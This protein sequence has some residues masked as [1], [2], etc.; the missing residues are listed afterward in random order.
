MSAVELNEIDKEGPIFHFE[1]YD[2]KYLKPQRWYERPQFQLVSAIFLVASLSLLIFGVVIGETINQRTFEKMRRPSL[3]WP[4]AIRTPHAVSSDNLQCSMIGATVLLDGGNA[5]DAAVAT[6]ICTSVMLPHS[7]GI[8]GGA[9]MTIVLADGTRV[10]VDG[11]EQAPNASRSNMLN[12]RSPSKGLFVGVP[13][14][15]SALETAWQ[16]YKSGKITWAKL[17]EP[18]LKLAEEG[19]TIREGLSEVINSSDRICIQKGL[20]S[21]AYSEQIQDSNMG[22]IFLS[23]GAPLTRGAV[24]RNPRLG[25]T[26]RNVAENGTW[27]F[28]NG[29]IAQKMIRDITDDGRGIMTLSDLAG[30]AARVTEPLSSTFGAYRV[31]CPGLPHTGCPILLQSLNTLDQ[32][33][34]LS[35]VTSSSYTSS[36]SAHLMAESFK[37]AFAQ[38]AKLGDDPA[39][40]SVVDRMISKD[41]AQEIGRKINRYSVLN[42]KN[43][44]DVTPPSVMA[45]DDGGCQI[46]VI[47]PSLNSVSLTTGLNS[48]FGSSFVS[49]S[50]GVILNDVM[51]AFTPEAD[52]ISTNVIAANKRPLSSWSPSVVVMETDK[53]PVLALGA[54]GGLHI[55]TALVNFLSYFSYPPSRSS[56]ST[57]QFRETLLLN[58]TWRSRLH[59]G[60]LPDRVLLEND[61]S[62]NYEEAYDR[63]TS[64]GNTVRTANPNSDISVVMM[65]EENGGNQFEVVMDTRSGDKQGMDGGPPPPGP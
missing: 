45:K 14:F 2:L 16:R 41:F 58:A 59:A 49:L 19:F 57:S 25:E 31:Y 3:T 40:Q 33:N 24:L 12:V 4:T 32:F 47:D 55:P 48:P 60:W 42:Y 36:L 6:A 50:T 34:H 11:R 27:S 15:L 35:E 9:V 54:S 46:S 38:K 18:S 17:F 10:I 43:Y 52:D 30:Y 1:Q 7:S 28:Y 65:Q 23:K 5:I 51:N 20:R 37:F 61:F 22:D 56:G 44:T 26:L 53:T 29:P 62:I 64:V 8:G 13:G 63:L 21:Q 39:S